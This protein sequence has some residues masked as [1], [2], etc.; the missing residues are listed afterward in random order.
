MNCSCGG[1]ARAATHK[2]S[3]DGL[4][5]C[6]L[7]YKRLWRCGIVGGPDLYK[8]WSYNGT[9]CKHCPRKA[10]ARG[11]CIVHYCKQWRERRHGEFFEGLKP[12]NEEARKLMAEVMKGRRAA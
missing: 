3:V 8:R 1:C 6:Y 4:R 5:Y 12:T 10:T 7:H 11:L 9:P 2:S